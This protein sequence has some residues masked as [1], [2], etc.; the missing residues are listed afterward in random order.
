MKP[1]RAATF[2]GVPVFVTPGGFLLLGGIAVLLALNVYP[3]VFEEATTGV[4]LAMAVVM[5]TS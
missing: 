4:H 3:Q 2:F 5:E 1:L